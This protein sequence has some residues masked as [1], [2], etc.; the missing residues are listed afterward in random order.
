MKGAATLQQPIPRIPEPHRRVDVSTWL[1]DY[2]SAAPVRDDVLAR[3]S[4][5]IERYGCPLYA[6]NGRDPIIDAYQ[7]ALDLFV[8]LG[9]AD[10]EDGRKGPGMLTRQ[11]L[12]LIMAIR[13]EMQRR[14]G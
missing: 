2:Y 13:A 8:Y 7:E 5:G 10:I 6:F 4:I 11:A 12:E 9:Q 3:R 1:C 14:Q